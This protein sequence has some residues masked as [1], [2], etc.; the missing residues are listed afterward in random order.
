MILHYHSGEGS[1]WKGGWTQVSVDPSKPMEREVARQIAATRS[2]TVWEWPGGDRS[3]PG[4]TPTSCSGVLMDVDNAGRTLDD[5]TTLE[6][7]KAALG[8]RLAILAPSRNHRKEKVKEDRVEPAVDRIHV[9]LPFEK[10]VPLASKEEAADFAARMKAFA[11]G[12]VPDADPVC[13]DLKRVLSV[14]SGEAEVVGEAFVDPAAFP[15]LPKKDRARVRKGLRVYSGDLELKLADGAVVRAEDVEGRH[16][17]HCPF[18]DDRSPSAFVNRLEDGRQFVH[19]ATCDETWWLDG[20][21][22]LDRLFLLDGTLREVI[23]RGDLFSTARFDPTI[24]RLDKAQLVDFKA[25][26]REDGRFYGDGFRLENLKGGDREA[27]FSFGRDGIRFVHAIAQ[28]RGDDDAFVDAWLDRFFGEHAD[29]IRKWLAIF[30]F[31]NYVQLPVLILAG[32][33]GSGKSTFGEFV[34]AIYPNMGASMAGQDLHF[35]EELE[36]FCCVVDDNANDKR[37]LYDSI[38]AWTGRGVVPINRKY[39]MKFQ[40][41]INCSFIVTSNSEEPIYLKFDEA[42]THDT[43][44]QWFFHRSEALGDELRHITPR[45]KRAAG[46]YARTR[47][48]AIH[49]DW[50]ASRERETCRYGLRT[51]ITEETRLQFDNARSQVDEDALVVLEAMVHGKAP[52]FSSFA[53]K[54]PSGPQVTVQMISDALLRLDLKSS[55]TASARAIKSSLVRQR[56]L[57]REPVRIVQGTRWFAV[58]SDDPE[59]QEELPF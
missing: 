36:S 37:E 22:A 15:E 42:P 56:L 33:R 20:E 11:L 8:D 16:A 58:Y 35:N 3:G 5:Q 28:D 9:F 21:Q 18:H 23:Q 6:D 31:S 34:H 19:C 32:E 10:P 52:L 12:I 53:A 38:K 49:D 51:P 30:A 27:H 55:R 48:K 13:Y 1:P 41:R 2:M 26:L 59:P 25:R 14:G 17:V 44:N 57:S 45:L 46:H 47:L 43:N 7:V 4:S 54:T 39:G 40:Y 50:V 24:L 29:F